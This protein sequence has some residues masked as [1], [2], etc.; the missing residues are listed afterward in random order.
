MKKKLSALLASVLLIATLSGC[1]NTNDNKTGSTVAGVSDSN[2]YATWNGIDRNKVV[3]HIEGQDSEK[4]DVTFGEFYS[5][6][7]Y[8]LLSYNI[9]DDMNATYKDQCESFREEIITYLTFEK[10]FLEVA[11][12]MGCGVSSLTDEEKEIIN[13]NIETTKNNFISNYTSM[14]KEELGEGASED[15]ILNRST[16]MLVNDL[17]RAELTTDI[18]EKWE[19]NNFIQE[20]LLKLLT[21]DITVSDSDVEAMYNDYVEMAKKALEADK[22]SYEM[23]STLTLVYVPDGTRLADQ[24]LVMFDEETRNKI[25]EARTAGNDAE[26]DKIREEAYNAEMQE[27]V[28]SIYSLIESGSDFDKLQETYNEDGAND[29]YPVIPGSALYVPEFTEAIF[30]VDNI[31][32]V[33]EAAISDY[34]AHIIKYVGDDSVTAEEKEEIYASMKDYIVYQ[35]ETEIQ[36]KAY[37]EW[38]ERFPYTIDYALLKITPDAD[39]DDAIISE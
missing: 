19:T 32:D 21:K 12:E 10:T 25:K 36:Q 34:G 14:A 15:E 38:M 18:F 39:A 26:A 24:I 2:S 22:V 5:E 17:A 30:S 9:S 23:D 16:E 37:E 11:E 31:G 3:A 27:K 33:A 4:F 13:T 29:P 7:L 35:K 8:Y 1:G 6:Y 28:N 20:K